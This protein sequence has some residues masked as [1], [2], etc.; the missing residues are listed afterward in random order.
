MSVMMYVMGLSIIVLLLGLIATIGY[1]ERIKKEVIN[2]MEPMIDLRESLK[3][4][5]LFIDDLQRKVEK[6][7]NE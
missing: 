5:K 4:W 7:I 2:E 6:T 3:Q 1:I